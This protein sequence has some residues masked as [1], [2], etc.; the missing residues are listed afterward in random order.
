MKRFFRSNGFLVVI[1]ALLLAGLIALGLSFFGVNPL[2]NL[3][4]IVATPF[5]NL[6]ASVAEWV[7][8]RY[9]RTFRYEELQAENDALRRMLADMEAAAREGEDAVR[10][11][12]RLKELLGLAK[13][14]PELA[15][16]DAM[17]TRR[18]TSN[19]EADVTLN[20][21]TS[22]GVAVNDCV[23]DQYG[24]LV[25]VVEEVGLNWSLVS[26][27]LDPDVEVGGRIARTDDDAILEGDFALMQ[28][29]QMKLSYLPADTQLVSGDQVITSGLGGVLP[30]G[31]MV[32]TIRSLYTE[33]DG[34]TRYAVVDPAADIEDL[35]YVY[36]ITDFGG[37]P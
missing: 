26:T 23:I 20:K 2:T 25:G 16:E 17:I 37:E 33:A 31:L 7:Q 5:R 9:D 1:V 24:N 28:N 22:D 3:G 8:G 30:A 34:L 11:N 36:V 12:E 18:A 4:E 27:I 15:Y 35:R 14:R 32:G 19:W 6:S 10:E 29:K 13:Q 21:G